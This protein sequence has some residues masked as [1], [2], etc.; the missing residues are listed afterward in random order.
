M[1]HYMEAG[2]I[3]LLVFGSGAIGFAL[4]LLFDRHAEI[5]TEGLAHVKSLETREQIQNVRSATAQLK[6]KMAES[7]RPNNGV[8]Q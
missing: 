6:E 7:P 4:R 8:C 2:A 5:K 1:E 3:A